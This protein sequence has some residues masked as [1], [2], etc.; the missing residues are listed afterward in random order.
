MTRLLSRRPLAH[1]V[2]LAHSALTLGG[3]AHW[4]VEPLVPKVVLE[5]Q[6]PSRIRVVQTDSSRFEL[7]YPQLEGDTIR[8]SNSGKRRSVPLDRVA[9]VSTRQPDVVQTM[10]LVAGALTVGLVTLVAATYNQ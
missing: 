2:L 4:E 8:G 10:L 9:Y 5:R 6:H 1:C 3:C 7:R